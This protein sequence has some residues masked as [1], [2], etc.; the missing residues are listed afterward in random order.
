MVLNNNNNKIVDLLDS[1]RV[2]FF[3][4][5]F[6][7]PLTFCLV[8]PDRCDMSLVDNLLHSLIG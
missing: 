1:L 3:T 5:I 8:A 6:L 4:L 7:K 2:L